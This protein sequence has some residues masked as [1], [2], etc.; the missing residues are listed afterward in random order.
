MGDILT[1][2][3]RSE[4]ARPY[5]AKALLLAQTVQ[6]EFQVGWVEGLKQKLAK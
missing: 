5:Y 4:E 2:M 6:P 1:D 3:N